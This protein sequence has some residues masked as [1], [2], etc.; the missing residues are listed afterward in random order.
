MIHWRLSEIQS[1]S[2]HI[3]A[4]LVWH[5]VP[6]VGVPFVQLHMFGIV[7]THLL[8]SKW[9]PS[10]HL[11]HLFSPFIG[12][13]SPVDPVPFVHLHSFA[14]YKNYNTYGC[15]NEVEIYFDILIQSHYWK[16]HLNIFLK[17]QKTYRYC[18]NS[19]WKSFFQM[20][21]VGSYLNIA[22]HPKY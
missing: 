6:V 16:Y 20:Q 18:E 21:N 2:E 9:N 7:H 22:L 1:H 13:S 15:T 11:E 17:I 12:Q 3:L 8:S 4:P 19:F 10:W 14:E 5:F